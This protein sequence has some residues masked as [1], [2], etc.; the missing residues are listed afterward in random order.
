[1][2]LV[3]KDGEGSKVIFERCRDL[4]ANDFKFFVDS[5]GLPALTDS[6]QGED[7]KK[8]D[9]LIKMMQSVMPDYPK[10]IGHTELTAQIVSKAKIKE[11][12][13]KNRIS[14]LLVAG[15]IIKNQMGM[16]VRAAV[17][18]Q[19]EIALDPID[20]DEMPF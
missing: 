11:R 18:K 13:A 3:K 16:Y 19:Q 1:M 2:L 6:E 9:K 10:S 20:D 4:A 12:T 5:K 8:R 17:V 14:E 15:L 7:P